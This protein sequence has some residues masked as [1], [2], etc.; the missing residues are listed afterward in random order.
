MPGGVLRILKGPDRRWRG[1]H[2][3]SR[4]RRNQHEIVGQ[5]ATLDEGVLDVEEHFE[6]RQGTGVIRAEIAGNP[7]EQELKQRASGVMVGHDIE[8]L[9]DDLQNVGGPD[10]F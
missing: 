9:T 5:I 1:A 10:G 4:P 2:V 8:T 7:V 3:L 6:D